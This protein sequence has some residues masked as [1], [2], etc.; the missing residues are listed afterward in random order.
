MRIS[1]NKQAMHGEKTTAGEHARINN[2]VQLQSSWYDFNEVPPLL[3][4]WLVAAGDGGG[5]A[6]VRAAL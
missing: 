2:V 1:R 6:E 5:G 3:S 4:G